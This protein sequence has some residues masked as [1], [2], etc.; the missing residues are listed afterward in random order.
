MHRVYT[1]FAFSVEVRLLSIG[2]V[3]V[4]NQSRRVVLPKMP[5]FGYWEA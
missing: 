3:Y 5:A 2:K 1:V 4:F